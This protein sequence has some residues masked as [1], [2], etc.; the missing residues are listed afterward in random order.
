MVIKQNCVCFVLQKTVYFV[1]HL[2]GLSLA[3]Y[4]VTKQILQ[5]Q[6]NADKSSFYFKKYHQEEEDKY[7]TFSICFYADDRY[8]G[9]LYQEDVINDTLGID[10]LEY[11]NMLLGDSIGPTNFSLLEYDDAKWDLRIILNQYNMR[12]RFL[13]FP[14]C[15]QESIQ[16]VKEVIAF[17]FNPVRG[18]L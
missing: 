8:P 9:T 18:L 5:Y 3:I 11:Q 13:W 2:L 7:P 14:S 1:F 12:D 10:A 16:S 6:E 17:S 15:W 4:F